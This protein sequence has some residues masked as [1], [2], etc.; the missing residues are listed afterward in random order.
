[1]FT[2]ERRCWVYGTLVQ[3]SYALLPPKHSLLLSLSFSLF[4]FLPSRCCQIVQYLY[5]GIYTIVSSNEVAPLSPLERQR[6]LM[7]NTRHTTTPHLLLPSPH[8]L[9]ALVLKHQDEVEP[10]GL[11]GRR[12]R[13]VDCGVHRG[14]QGDASQHV[15]PVAVLRDQHWWVTAFLP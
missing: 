10:P 6:Y 11:A 7:L 5:D 15:R 13:S 2:Q 9:N 8:P 12:R 4:L 3:S 1:M 14:G